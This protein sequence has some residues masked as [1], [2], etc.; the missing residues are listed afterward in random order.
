M[1]S[2]N[3]ACL[4]RTLDGEG[5]GDTWLGVAA[6]VPGFRVAVTPWLAGPV[7]V[8]IEVGFDLLSPPESPTVDVPDTGT[9]LRLAHRPAW[10]L[11]VGVG[12]RFRVANRPQ[13]GDA[14]GLRISPQFLLGVARMQPWVGSRYTDRHAPLDGG[15]AQL[16]TMGAALDVRFEA[17][18]EDRALIVLGGR[19][20]VSIP[21]REA[22]WAAPAGTPEDAA[23]G[24]ASALAGDG[25]RA[26]GAAVELDVGVLGRPGTAPLTLCPLLAVTWRT[27]D[28]RLPNT[29][30]DV[31]C[32]QAEGCTGDE[33]LRT[34]FS[35]RRQAL[36]VRVGLAVRFGA[37]EVA[38][39]RRELEGIAPSEEAK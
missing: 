22:P 3:A 14:M 12:P 26:G 36:A 34:A 18:I 9:P 29:V 5:P 1:G 4:P 7:G 13:A 30:D 11:D 24:A 2:I 16:L 32:A 23:A 19:G 28:L 38:E 27:T 10:A 6:A 21:G 39:V 20:A 37:G 17:E 35:T 31:W 15:D 25:W 33:G 8:G